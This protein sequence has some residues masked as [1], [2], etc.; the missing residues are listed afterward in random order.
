MNAA[1]WNVQLTADAAQDF[2]RIIRWTRKNFGARQVQTYRITLRE[3][4]KALHAGPDIIGVKRRDDLGC[5]IRTL[6]VA[7]NGRKGHH[8]VVFRIGSNSS[9]DVLRLLH[10]GMDLPAHLPS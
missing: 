4:L 10:D 6:H 3:T 1:R 5:G 2:V 7:R 9:I 8:F